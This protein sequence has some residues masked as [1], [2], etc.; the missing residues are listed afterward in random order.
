MDQFP[1]SPITIVSLIGE[2]KKGMKCPLI[3]SAKILS[4]QSLY[5][6]LTAK[7]LLDS[8]NRLS[9]ILI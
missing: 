3:K 2:S 9:T 8:V 5:W 4:V 1:L 6:E 7:F